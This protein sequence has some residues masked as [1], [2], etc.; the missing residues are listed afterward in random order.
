MEIW[1]QDEGIQKI[2]PLIVEKRIIPI[3][4]AGFSKGFKSKAGIVPDS[5]KSKELMQKL[6]ITSTSKISQKELEGVSFTETADLF[7]DLVPIEIR[8]NFFCDY[9]T[10]VIIEGEQQKLL[11]LEWPYA[12]TL[13]IDDG[14]ENSS[15]FKS[16]LPYKD[17][18]KSN[19][20]NKLLY[21]LHGDAS[22]EILYVIKKNII[23]SQDQYISA[24]TDRNNKDFLNSLTADFSENNIIFIG[25]SLKNEID[26][27]FVYNQIKNPGENIWRIVTKSA[28]ESKSISYSEELEFQKHGINCV[29]IIDN[30]EDFYKN[31]VSEVKKIYQTNPLEDYRF[32]NPKIEIYTEKEKSLSLISGIRI[33]DEA[34]NCF[35]KSKYHIERTC[36]QE[37]EQ[38]INKNTCVIIKGR[39]FCGKTFLLSSLCE[40]VQKYTTFFFPSNTL[41]DEQ[42]ISRLLETKKNSIL[43]FDSNSFSKS[44]YTVVADSYKSIV[45]N[46]NKIIF[47]VNSGDN[48]FIETVDASVIDLPSKFDENELKQFNEIASAHG[49]LERKY[50][51]TNLDYLYSLSHN[52]DIELP[53]DFKPA[54]SLTF[55]EQILTMLLCSSD[56]V[57]TGDAIA[58]GIQREELTAYS[59][60]IQ[61]I[62]EYIKTEPSESENHSKCK[63]IHNSKIVLLSIL[64]NFSS[65]DIVKIIKYIV[66]ELKTDANRNKIYSDLILFDTLN[67]LFGGQEGAGHL[68]IE[69]Y[70]SLEEELG[71]DLHYWLQRAKSIYRLRYNDRAEMR[72]ALGYATKAYYD[73]KYRPIKSQ[74]ALTSSLICCLL[75]DLEEDS[76]KK[77]KY[78][79]HAIEF[80]YE[81]VFSKYFTAHTRYLNKELSRKYGKKYRKNSYDLIYEICI[82]YKDKENSDELVNKK[83][84]EKADEILDQLEYMKEKNNYNPKKY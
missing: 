62:L 50:R 81:A 38:E 53:L 54:S 79:L 28:T 10:D 21:K 25:C 31:L 17:V 40:R 11:E 44:M 68:I 82:E 30:Y 22:T 36:Q 61:I 64:Q 60:K 24:I 77:D 1:K 33:F 19:T 63:L 69:V 42:V 7:Y 58:L 46:N 55:N 83:T 9:F 78:Q 73:G 47:A 14:I 12:Y 18:N 26:I 15:N 57:F 37:V 35:N 71:E 65:T 32:T 3:F 4:G 76:F 80:A 74:A 8:T 41:V 29:L 70:E 66:H 56:K 16:V 23:F 13:N 52:Q 84:I 72:K 20:S 49:L 39:R 34:N 6:I 67:Q 5:S 51:D 48:Y 45:A 59:K 75:Y 27:K 43:I 2:A